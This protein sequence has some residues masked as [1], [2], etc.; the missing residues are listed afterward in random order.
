M[1]NYS[2]NRF[3]ASLCFNDLFYTTNSPEVIRFVI[4]SDETETHEV[5]TNEYFEA[6]FNKCLI[7]EMIRIQMIKMAADQFSADQ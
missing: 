5:G 2:S 1:I 3:L 4:I 7:W 6:L